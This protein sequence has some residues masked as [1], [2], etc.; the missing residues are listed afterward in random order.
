MCPSEK[1]A[2]SKDQPTVTAA[3]EKW[4][5]KNKW[6]RRKSSDVE[7]GTFPGDKALQISF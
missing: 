2:D 5:S 3:F 6:Q 4:Q 1:A 7:E